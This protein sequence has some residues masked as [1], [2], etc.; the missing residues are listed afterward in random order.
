[1]D[2]EL[3]STIYGSGNSDVDVNVHIDMVSLAYMYACS[4]HATGQIT[5]RQFDDMIRKYHQL[6]KKQESR[7]IVDVRTPVKKLGPP[8]KLAR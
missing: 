3:L 1:M 2:N 8:R 7:D 5:E 4:L 6:M